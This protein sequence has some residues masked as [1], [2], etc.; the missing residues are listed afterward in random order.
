MRYIQ[1]QKYNF[2]TKHSNLMMIR[3]LLLA[4]LLSVC[5]TGVD[6]NAQNDN[7]DY[8]L[9]KGNFNTGIKT[10]TAFFGFS[11][12][13]WH[14]SHDQLLMYMRY[15]DGAS[16]RITMHEY[17]RTIENRPLIYMLVTT[18]ENHQN[19]E[20]IR[21]EHLDRIKNGNTSKNKETPGIL[22]QGYS[23]HGN[24]A[25]GINAAVI[26]AYY[27]AAFNDN[28][29]NELLSKSI[30]LLDPC[31][32][33]DGVQRFSTWVNSHK[34]Q[35]LVSD[36]N[37]REFNETW[38]GGRYNH[39][40]FDLNRDW[41]PLVH[42][43]S[44][45]RIKLFNK[46]RP[47]LLTDHH[48]M[49]TNST[50]FFQPGIPSR[51]NPNTPAEN[52]VLTEKLAEYHAGALD[53]IGSLYFTKEIFDDFYYG[54]GSTYPEARGC[55]GILF[56]QAS[57]RGHLQESVNGPVAFAFTIRNQV[58]TSLS[59][60][61]GFLKLRREFIDYQASFQ[62]SMHNQL[63]KSAAKGWIFTDR[64]QWKLND[65]IS[66]LLSHE[67]EVF[68]NVSDIT[69]NGKKYEGGKSYIVP[70]IQS[71]SI[72][73]K[74]FFEKV[75]SFQDSTFYDISTWTPS[76]AYDLQH[77]EIT[78]MSLSLK[79]KITAP[80]KEEM[81]LLGP[82]EN[83]YAYISSV[84]DPHTH[85]FIYDLLKNQIQVKLIHQPLDINE[86][87]KTNAYAPGSIII[88]V[89]G[90]QLDGKALQIKLDSLAK[91]TSARICALKSGNGVEEY[92]L[93]HPDLDALK[94]PVA[95]LLAGDGI[96]PSSAGEIWHHFDEHLKI[97]LSIIDVYKFRSVSL[98]RYNIL[99]L[100]SGQYHRLMESDA[101][102]IDEWIKKG[103]TLILIDEAIT[104][105]TKN[106]LLQLKEKKQDTQNQKIPYNNL[107]NNRGAKVLAGSIFKIEIDPS[108]PLFYGYDTKH[109][110]VMHSGTRFYEKPNQPMASP[111]SYPKDFL[112]SGYIPKGIEK[113]V[114]DAPAITVHRLE[115]GRII[116]F[117]DNP[118]FRGFWKAGYYMFN[119]ALFF[120]HTIKSESMER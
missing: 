33:P 7:I 82:A 19:I 80:K 97:P 73:A 106:N 4:I 53:S 45:A 46:W 71:E 37:S 34:S 67:I 11:S 25:S 66:L 68:E 50:F 30:I 89:Q 93:G 41:L 113:E 59:S 42:K 94:L 28:Y 69:I 20:T 22:Y 102:K 85:R 60:Q 55:V 112:T 90:Q 72:L 51:N 86:S 5:F 48:E 12:G 56:E 101:K 40:W 120:G 115:N 62:K 2:K 27:L 6:L 79:N 96:E 100:A 76:L 15:L 63:D 1:Q 36:P 35:S 103:N 44:K 74:T 32:N 8:F 38:P 109:T 29:I 13:E 84:K 105:A 78:Q 108:H 70:L 81:G 54:K 87:G 21:S 83:A 52:F 95:A 110:Y 18:P 114:A 31:L 88:P 3:K 9:P 17:G 61:K 92:T 107:S 111:A 116:A 119:N 10:P 23:I 77:D 47:H 118:L 49:G 26:V 117:Q 91:L 16:E 57:S 75:R 99:L 98:D 64:S 65:F 39:Y 24:E 58:V 14:I 43:E 104:W